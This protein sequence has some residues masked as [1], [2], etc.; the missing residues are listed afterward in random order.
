APD[1]MRVLHRCWVVIFAVVVAT[2][3]AAIPMG[4]RMNSQL[5]P[6][7]LP[8]ERW[9]MAAVREALAGLGLAEPVFTL[10]TY[11]AS[12]LLGSVCIAVAAFIVWQK[13]H[14]QGAVTISSLLAV[15][16]WATGGTHLILES[17]YPEWQ[18]LLRAVG[19]TAFGCLTLLL[20]VFPDGSFVPRWTVWAAVVTTLMSPLNA[21]DAPV[22]PLSWPAPISVTVGLVSLAIP[23]LAQVH[24]YRL[25]SDTQQRQQTKWVALSVVILTFGSA[26]VV[27]IWWLA[28]DVSAPGVSGLQMHLFSNAWLALLM[29]L[30]PI[31]I[32]M[33]VLRLRLWDV[34]PLLNRTLVYGTLT[35]LAGSLYIVTSGLLS[36]VFQ[37]P[38]NVVSSLLAAGVIAVLFDPGRRWLQGNVNRLMY[39]ERDNPY[40][41]MSR[42][43]RRLEGAPAP[44]A[45][46]TTI[47]QTV[48]EAFRVPHATIELSGWNGEVLAALHDPPE[49]R[50]P[51]AGARAADGFSLPLAYRGES[52]GRLIVAPRAAGERFSTHDQ[53]LLED[54]AR[55]AGTAVYAVR[56]ATELQLAR[57]RLVTAGQEERR[58]LRRHLHDVLGPLLAT[59]AMKLDVAQGLM[60]RDPVSS[61]ELVVE[62]QGQLQET[63]ALV[64]R[65]VYTLYP[66]VLDELGLPTA[67]R[68]QASSQLQ[69]HGVAVD[70]ELPTTLPPLPAATEVAAYYIAVEA[71]TNIKRHARANCCR[72]RLTTQV[73]SMTLEVTD[74]GCGIATDTRRGAGLQS[75]RERAQELGGSFDITS[76]SPTGTR[77]HAELPLAQE[78]S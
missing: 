13:P 16:G 27:A 33:A 5:T 1:R 32:M 11:L 29:L 51:D 45:V 9:S 60:P 37:N 71:M 12:V 31:A 10:S 59:L 76:A 74:D 40:L 44:E 69:N 30:V 22:N 34:D 19:I 65:L 4:V 49:E 54:L 15:F 62:V 66:P 17:L 46:L 55:H 3:V 78:R 26:P 63:L 68:E 20:Y 21:L 57:E 77:V 2:F 52:I 6:L 50:R 64:R 75:M 18:V 43:A 67:I 28:P 8:D 38:G 58:R 7:H 39:G 56:A 42:L 61:Q 24:R 53:R 47:T 25:V 14:D 73:E 70:L 36:A 48:R 23:L 35:L 41:V 72:L